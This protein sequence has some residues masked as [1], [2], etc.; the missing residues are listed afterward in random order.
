ASCSPRPAAA[1]GGAP[2]LY[3]SSFPLLPCPF[4]MDIAAASGSFLEPARA[5]TGRWRALPLIFALLGV[6]LY[7]PAI[8]G[9]F[10]WDDR[11]VMLDS[12]VLRSYSPARA[13]VD[14]H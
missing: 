5:A 11:A 10:I 4:P 7:L 2:P 13:F 14:S 9:D 1:P 6:A 12:D 3:S 8:T